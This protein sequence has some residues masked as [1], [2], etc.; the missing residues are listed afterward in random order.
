MDGKIFARADLST[1][2]TKAKKDTRLFGENGNKGGA[3]CN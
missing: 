3:K 2:Q 1:E